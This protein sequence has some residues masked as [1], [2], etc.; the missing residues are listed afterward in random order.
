MK[1]TLK[2]IKILFPYNPTTKRST[3]KVSLGTGKA[4]DY[5]P[6]IYSSSS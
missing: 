3:L 6:E 1:L 5:N 2:E 4:P